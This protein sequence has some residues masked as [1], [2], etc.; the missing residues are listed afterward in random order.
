MVRVLSPDWFGPLHIVFGLCF[1][2]TVDTIYISSN[3]SW[4]DF[5][6]L[7][8]FTPIGGDYFKILPTGSGGLN[9]LFI[10]PL[11]EKNNHIKY[12]E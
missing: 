7:F 1:K 3:N 2:Y 11:S 12:T 5:L 8:F 6:F 10:I 4:D 9:I